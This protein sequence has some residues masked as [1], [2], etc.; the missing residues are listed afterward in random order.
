MIKLFKTIHARKEQLN[1]L[2]RM[3][4]IG[5]QEDV[6]MKCDPSRACI[7]Q[8]YSPSL[9]REHDSLEGYPL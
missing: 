5:N 3:Q 1:Q 9:S 7:S 6:K 4:R 8:H 2:I